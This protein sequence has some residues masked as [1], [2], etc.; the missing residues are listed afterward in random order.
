MD[1]GE[2]VK[3]RCLRLMGP[4]RLISGTNEEKHVRLKH[5]GVRGLNIADNKGSVGNL[6]MSLFIS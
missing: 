4:K 2:C 6:R 3:I 1:I 5:K